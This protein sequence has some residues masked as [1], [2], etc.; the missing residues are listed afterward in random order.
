MA[1]LVVTKGFHGV[2]K[3]HVARVPEGAAPRGILVYFGGDRI[4]Q[5]G[6][7]PEITRLQDPMEVCSIMAR[8][9]PGCDVVL[10]TP[11]RVEA[12]CVA[13][14]HFFCKLT[15]TG[16]PLGY[17]GSSYKASDQLYS[18]LLAAGVVGGG[19]P[20]PPVTVVG[21]SKGGVLLNQV[22]FRFFFLLIFRLIFFI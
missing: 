9:F 7:D 14:E 20:F 2:N 6:A 19:S 18:L 16:E 15:L 1:K 21:F 8:K 17:H 5:F 10:V 13:Y 3:L 22:S 4:E 12:G 11:S